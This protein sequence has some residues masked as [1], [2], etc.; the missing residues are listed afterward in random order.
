MNSLG[1][2]H[3]L[4]ALVGPGSQPEDFDG[5]RL[6]YMVMPDEMRVFSMAAIPEAEVAADHAAGLAAAAEVLGAL[7]AVAAG[8]PGRSVDVSGLDPADLRF[9]DQL[10]GEGEVSVVLGGD[11]Q[12]QESVLAGVWRVRVSGADGRRVSDRVDVGAFPLG[13]VDRAFAGASATV[14]LPEAAFEGV[15]NAPALLAEINAH[16]GEARADGDPHVINL[17]LL[18]HTE[19]DLALLEAALGQGELIILSRGYGNCRIRSTQTRDCWRVRY[20]NSQDTLILDAIEISPLPAVC[21]AA[22]EDIADSADRLREIMA[23][24]R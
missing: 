11:T 15:F 5:G 17:S 22:R 24:Y 19:G 16:A 18:P 4:G 7:D 2:E 3:G 10:L 6:E 9:L 13:L 23:I 8:A 1:P 21:Q 20:F 14:Q 12:A